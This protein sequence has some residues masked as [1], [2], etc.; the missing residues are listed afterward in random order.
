MNIEI[1]G[2]NLAIKYDDGEENFL[3]IEYLRKNCPCARCLGEKDLLGKDII[4]ANK[5]QSFNESQL[6][7]K[8]IEKVGNYG[9]KPVWGD[10]HTSGIYS[11]DL[12]KFLNSKNN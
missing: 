2:K 11:I 7:I 10:N 3:D 4:K 1:I 12:L 9:I 6:N 8:S 5:N